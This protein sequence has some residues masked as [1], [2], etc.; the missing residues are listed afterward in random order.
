MELEKPYHEA[1]EKVKNLE[2]D[3]AKDN[4]DLSTVSLQ[5]T[6]LDLTIKELERE[7][8]K[9]N[10]RVIKISDKLTSVAGDS[11]KETRYTERLE[12]EHSRIR[13]YEKSLK[14]KQDELT[15]A[16]SKHQTIE[17][18]MAAKVNSLDGARTE[19]N[20]H[21]SKRNALFS[22]PE[23]AV[24]EMITARETE[25]LTKS[26]RPKPLLETKKKNLP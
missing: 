9:S 6:S 8:K 3:L 25:A 4:Q 11:I 13:E 7:L 16:T 12:L 20:T 2:A 17:E 10:A 14:E 5:K 24:V 23:S 1:R 21:Q 18:G 15:V 22:Q 19:L 26:I